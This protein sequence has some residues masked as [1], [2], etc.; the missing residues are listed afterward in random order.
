MFYLSDGS[1]WPVS[2]LYITNPFIAK[3]G[4]SIAVEM[5]ERWIFNN[6]LVVMF[7]R[8][9]AGAF[10]LNCLS[11][12]WSKGYQR[13]SLRKSHQNGDFLNASNAK[14]LSSRRNR[15]CNLRITGPL[16]WVIRR[17]QSSG[18]VIRKLQIPEQWTGNP[19]A[20][21]SIPTGRQLFRIACV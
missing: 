20:A 15:T 8:L 12:I 7:W 10:I 16:L 14:K 13:E 1:F 11:A 2:T 3:I 9:L 4:A 6:N 5:I 21:G 18:P 17:L 19:K